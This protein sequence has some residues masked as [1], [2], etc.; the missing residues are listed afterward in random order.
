M[1][2]S[3]TSPTCR[4]TARWVVPDQALQ[5]TMRQ[6]QARHTVASHKSH[7]QVRCIPVT[8]HKPYVTRDP[9]Q[10]ARL[11]RRLYMYKTAITHFISLLPSAFRR[12]QAGPRH[13]STS[14]TVRV[15]SSA[16]IAF[17][18][19]E[20]STQSQCTLRLEAPGL[21]AECTT[22]PRPAVKSGQLQTG[23][24]LTAATCGSQKYIAKHSPQTRHEPMLSY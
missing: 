18:N 10:E 21:C 12:N 6:S 24:T 13:S 9:I 1:S 11:L 4:A 3:T 14:R 5:V 16:L 8:S 19:V 22:M 7:R 23:D 15:L 2:V 17:M 20:P